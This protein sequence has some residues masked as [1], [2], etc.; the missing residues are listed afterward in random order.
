MH[1]V[2]TYKKTTVVLDDTLVAG[3][4]KS[5]NAKTK[6]ESIEASLKELINKK[7]QGSVE[8]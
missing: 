1:I 2:Y 5:I 3:A 4:V 6:K 7:K 8:V